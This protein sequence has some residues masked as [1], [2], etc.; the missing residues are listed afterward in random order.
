MAEGDI[1]WRRP[2]PGTESQAAA[3]GYSGPPAGEPAT[4][5]WHLRHE[6]PVTAPR[7]LP[8]VDHDA[9]DDAEYRA[10]WVTYAIGFAALGVLLLLACSRLF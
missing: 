5:D 7:P 3:V 1:V 10:R 4:A 2:A 9:I 6:D 8:R